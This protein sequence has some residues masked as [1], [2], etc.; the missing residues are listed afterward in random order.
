MSKVSSG[1][2]LFAS[3]F[4]LTALGHCHHRPNPYAPRTP[5]TPSLG[6][7]F[8]SQGL[9]GRA[10]YFRP[11]SPYSNPPGSYARPV[12]FNSPFAMPATFRLTNP[13]VFPV[14]SHRRY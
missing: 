2:V 3:L 13:R 10:S 12:Y 7:N 6:W 8:P 4:V 9:S 1:L 5:G 14:P 11:Q